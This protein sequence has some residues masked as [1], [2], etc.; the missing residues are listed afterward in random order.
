MFRA[1][2]SLLREVY[3]FVLIGRQNQSLIGREQ[4]R[5][6]PGSGHLDMLSSCVRS[7]LSRREC[8]LFERRVAARIERNSL[9]VLLRL[10]VALTRTYIASFSWEGMKASACARSASCIEVRLTGSR[11]VS[12][13]RQQKFVRVTA[14]HSPTAS[15]TKL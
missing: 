7:R 15:A 4:S 12:E 1:E 13:G 9:H 5:I 8:R 3:R 11:F 6:F 14:F 10:G 2:T